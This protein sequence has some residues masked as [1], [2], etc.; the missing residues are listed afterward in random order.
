MAA[1]VL[2][3]LS[4]FLVLCYGASC[5]VVTRNGYAAMRLRQEIGA[6]RAQGALLRYQIQVTQSKQRIIESAKRLG[7]EPADPVRDVDYVA[8]PSSEGEME[9]AGAGPTQGEGGLSA[10][11][12]ELASGVVGSGRGEA[13][14]STGEGRRP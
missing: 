2:A 8:V 6:L 11:L 5:A 14:A 4:L 7:L 12:A 9:L 10:L 13:E 3:A 1:T